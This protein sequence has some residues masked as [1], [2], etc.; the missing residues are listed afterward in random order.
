MTEQSAPS[1]Q[2]ATDVTASVTEPT[3]EELL[4][5]EYRPFT[6]WQRCCVAVLVLQAIVTCYGVLLIK[7]F[8]SDYYFYF[9]TIFLLATILFCYPMIALST[10]IDTAVIFSII[11]FFV[12]IF[13]HN[14]F[15]Q[16]N[17]FIVSLSFH[18]SVIVM[19]LP[20]RWLG[21]GLIEKGVC[22]SDRW[23]WREVTNRW[24]LSLGRMM[25]GIAGGLV[26]LGIGLALGKTEYKEFAV[27]VPLV[28]L[29][30]VMV[31]FASLSTFCWWYRTALYILSI[32]LFF[33]SLLSFLIYIEGWEG[34]K[35]IIWTRNEHVLGPAL[36]LLLVLL[37]LYTDFWLL[38]QLGYR[39]GFRKLQPH[40]P[41]SSSSEVTATSNSSN[42]PP[43]WLSD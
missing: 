36:V 11:L 41:L 2:P 12:S 33:I 3:L 37:L 42:Q 14:S 29:A 27:V 39:I 43:S 23:Y 9:I 40:D 5:A 20:I 26:I 10:K 28:Y 21:L 32:V 34:L 15:D 17:A 8:N 7:S 24:Q 19:W 13:L 38:R 31:S 18:I 6:G 1:E 16:S 35:E 25:F 30:F 22:L 4:I